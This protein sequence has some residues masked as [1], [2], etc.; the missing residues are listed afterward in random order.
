MGASRPPAPFAY[1]AG[2]AARLRPELGARRRARTVVRISR[3]RRRARTRRS[4]TRPT[5]SGATTL[6]VP[7]LCH[8]KQWEWCYIAQVLACAGMNQPGRRGLGFGVGTEP[9]VAYLASTGSAIV[10]TDL[11][12]RRL[13]A[14]S[15]GPRPGST[16]PRS[17][18]LE[19]R[20]TVPRRAVPRAG[21]VPAGRHE[22][23]SRRSPRLRLHLVVVRA[24]APRRS[25]RRR[26]LLPAP[27]RLPAPGRRGRA[28]DRVQRLVER[29][30]GEQ[31]PH[32]A[33]P[34]PRHRGACEP[35][36]PPR[37]H[38]RRDVRIGRLRPKTVTSTVIRGR[39]R[40]SRSRA[41]GT[42]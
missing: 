15:A 2:P 40:I 7:M 1:P 5:H 29:G 35:R 34:A 20:R 8:R 16:R 28:H 19:S 25:R 32:R 3:S 12:R 11:A 33:L 22:R 30:D 21:D 10:A 26:R 17:V 39:T 42:S 36:S 6:R 23:R 38:D 37:P 18:E 13:G 14:R 27:D 41:A 4:A 31:G 9:I 24:R